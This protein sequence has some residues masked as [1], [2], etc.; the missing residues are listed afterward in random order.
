[1]M[2]MGFVY[3]DKSMRS[4]NS[5][6]Y[7]STFCLPWK[8]QSDLSRMSAVVASFSG[9]NTVVNSSLNLSQDA[10]HIFPVR[11]SCRIT[12]LAKVATCPPLK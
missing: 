3:L 2:V 5:S 12:C 10:K 1:M 4:L 7:A 6:M 8:Y 9:Q 11:I